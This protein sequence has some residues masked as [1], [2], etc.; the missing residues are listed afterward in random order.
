MDKKLKQKDLNCIFL[1]SFF[2]IIFMFIILNLKYQ[3]EI[4]HAIYSKELIN[5][6]LN[7]P[8]V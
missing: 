3:F 1:I 6:L 2:L 4:K 5:E 7:L 8:F